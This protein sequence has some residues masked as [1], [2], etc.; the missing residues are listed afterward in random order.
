MNRVPQL[1]S[2]I[3]WVTGRQIARW[4]LENMMKYICLNV[5]SM[6]RNCREKLMIPRCPNLS[7]K[8]RK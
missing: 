4:A 2:R 5:C 3:C 6:M 7:A 1:L 8:R